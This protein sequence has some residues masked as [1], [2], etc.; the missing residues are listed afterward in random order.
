MAEYRRKER[1]VPDIRTSSRKYYTDGS[2]ARQPK[3]VVRPRKKTE[4]K[5]EPRYEKRVSTFSLRYTAFLVLVVTAILFSC[6]TYLHAQSELSAAKNEVNSKQ[7]T[8]VLAQNQT[9]SLEDSLT[10]SVDLDE[11]YRIATGRLGMVYANE[12]QVI[13]YHSTNSDYV[14]QYQAIPDGKK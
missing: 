8:L 13:Y 9:S 2:A 14:R 5:E 3:E 1:N 4:V 7:A 12:D 10:T 6:F 11:V